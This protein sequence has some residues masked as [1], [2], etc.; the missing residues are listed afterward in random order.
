MMWLF[1]NAYKRFPFTIIS[2]FLTTL[3]NEQQPCK[4]IRSDEDGALEKS[5]NVTNLLIEEFKMSMETTG[6][7]ESWINGNNERQNRSIHNMVIS[8]LLYINQ[9]A[10]KW[11]CA[12]DTSEELHRCRI[13]SAL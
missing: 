3:N 13:H 6:G 10:K 8:G 5:K 2:F 9:H 1:P 12:A 7:D 4:H 11:C